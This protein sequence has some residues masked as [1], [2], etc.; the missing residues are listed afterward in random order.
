[1]PNTGNIILYYRQ[2]STFLQWCWICSERVCKSA[3]SPNILVFLSFDMYPGWGHS[4]DYPGI[5]F[6]LVQVQDVI[7]WCFTCLYA[8]YQCFGYHNSFDSLKYFIV[9]VFSKSYK[10]SDASTLTHQC[11]RIKLAEFFHFSSK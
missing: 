9:D 10:L 1:M 11:Q 8:F 4:S 6:S 3:I 7:R 2:I 5:F